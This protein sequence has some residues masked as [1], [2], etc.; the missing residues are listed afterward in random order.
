MKFLISILLI[1]AALGAQSQSLTSRI[2]EAKNYNANN[3]TTNAGK[4]ITGHKHNTMNQLIIDLLKNVVDTVR[5]ASSSGSNLTT[6][7]ALK[8][9]G[10]VLEV[11][12][13]GSNA[14]VTAYQLSTKRDTS[15]TAASFLLGSKTITLN[16]SYGTALQVPLTGLA[17]E[18]QLSDSATALRE[19]W[20][21]TTL[22]AVAGNN[23]LTLPAPVYGFWEKFH[24]N[25]AT[26]QTVN[27]SLD[28][29]DFLQLDLQANKTY[30]LFYH[31]PKTLSL[32]HI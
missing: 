15:V 4:L 25:T 8:F 26:D 11:D 10:L 32:I 23:T 2:T 28:G 16:K 17:S 29:G 18:L 19:L 9:T 14:L 7:Y 12:T 22:S 21:P 1:I 6:G 20:K 27:V 13:I 24:L 30:V 5:E 31:V 3:I